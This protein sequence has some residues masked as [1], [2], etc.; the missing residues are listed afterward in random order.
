MISHRPFRIFAGCAFVL[1]CSACAGE[2]KIVAPAPLE[3]N[4][5]SE[6]TIT[7]S[8]VP[9]TEQVSP[10]IAVSEEIARACRLQFD[11]VGQAPK[12]AFDK[13]E[14]LPADHEVLGNIG[15]CL[16]TGPL[17]GRSIKLVGRAD[18]RGTQQYNMALGARRANS[19]GLF[20]E[21][22]GVDKGRMRETSRGELDATGTNEAM[23]QFDRRVDILLSD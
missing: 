2:K 12:F 8:P 11:D 15:E 6:T 4:P 13:S 22:L 17:Q 20:L 1:L 14:L 9:A 21:Q 23:W 3:P 16:T 7:S 19:V 18:P 5:Y 10:S